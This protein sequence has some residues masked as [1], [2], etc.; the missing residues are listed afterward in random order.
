MVEVRH[1]GVVG[2]EDGE[3]GCGEWVGFGKGQG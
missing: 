3:Q 1:D 2:W